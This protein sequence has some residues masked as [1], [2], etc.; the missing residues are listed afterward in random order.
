MTVAVQHRAQPASAAEALPAAGR[1]RPPF[2]AEHVGSLLRPPPLQAARERFAKGEIGRDELTA[3]EDAAIADAV[4]LQEA[5]GL[6]SI[7]DGEFR[8]AYFH[9]DFLVQIEGMQSYVDQT[10]SHFRTAAGEVFDFIPPKLKITGK[11]ARTHPIMR[12]DH[13]VIAA[14]IAKGGTARVTVPSPSMAFRGGRGAI[15]ETAY[16]TLDAFHE[17]LARVYREEVA[18]LADA[19]CRYLQLDD[20]NLAYLCDDAMRDNARKMG[21]DPDALPAVY[22]KL[23]NDSLASAPQDMATAIHLCRGNFKSAFVAQGGYDPVAEVLFN[24]ID[25]DAFFLEYDDERSGDFSPL[26]FLPKG[27]FV[28][29]G[30]ISS[31]LARLETKDEVKR[32]IDE[33]ARFAPIEQLCLSPQCG[34]AST[35]HGNDLSFDDQRRKLELVVEVARDIWGEA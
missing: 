21:Q 32:R 16:P 8:R 23:I 28:V 29:L 12:R 27:K 18:D 34:F 14:N 17:D 25:I 20:T 10:A 24:E 1:S 30:V 15:D 26:R 31:K 6:R 35:C 5:V 7:T 3:I 9:L 11:L 33:A 19:G 4:A 2:R 13:E 22:A